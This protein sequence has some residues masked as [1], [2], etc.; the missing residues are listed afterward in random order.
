M[1]ADES[2]VGSGG[3]LSFMWGLV[4]SV[5]SVERWLLAVLEAG[6]CAA[7]ILASDRR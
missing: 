7:Y 2:T 3:I 4:D 6:E 1:D 5:R